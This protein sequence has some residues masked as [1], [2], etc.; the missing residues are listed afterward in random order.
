MAMISGSDFPFEDC[1]TPC[2]RILLQMIF[3][4]GA[5]IKVAYD[6]MGW[7]WYCDFSASYMGGSESAKAHCKS[8]ECKVLD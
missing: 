2:Q 6:C 3:K 1:A 8:N 7:F 4:V 5:M